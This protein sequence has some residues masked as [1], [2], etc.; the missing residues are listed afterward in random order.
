M[1]NA[2]V[3]D[4]DYMNNTPLHY[5]AASGNEA[6]LTYLLQK[7]ARIATSSDGSTP[8]HVVSNN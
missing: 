7:N 6:I 3:D 2:N 1:Q 5:A 8:L 4:V